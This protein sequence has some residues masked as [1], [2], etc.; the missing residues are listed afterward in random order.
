MGYNLGKRKSSYPYLQMV[1]SKLNNTKANNAVQKFSRLKIQMFNRYMEKCSVS[2]VMREMQIKTK[3]RFHVILVRM[4][5]IQKTKTKLNKNKTKKT[6]VS[7]NVE[8]KLLQ[9]SLWECK[10]IQPLCKTV[11]RFFSNLKMYLHM[12]Q[13]CY[14][15]EFTQME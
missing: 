2:L 11:R 1:F 7:E 10:Q 14:Y 9:V 6:N 13:L 4:A 8:I 3:M 5:M 12:T 15:W